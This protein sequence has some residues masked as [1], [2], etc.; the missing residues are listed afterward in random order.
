MS[1]LRIYP[2]NNFNIQHRA[3]LFYH[4]LHSILAHTYFVIESL[5]LLS[6]F[7]PFPLPQLIS[8]KLISFV[9]RLFIHLFVFC[10]EIKYNTVSSCYTNAVIQHFCAFQNDHHD[11]SSYHLLLCKDMT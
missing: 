6:A 7:I 10:V 5:Y 1:T 2:P 9:M 4:V 8:R 3:A 11:K